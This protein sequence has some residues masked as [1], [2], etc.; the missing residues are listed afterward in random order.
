MSSVKRGHISIVVDLT[1]GYIHRTD[2]VI[3]VEDVDVTRVVEL[4]GETKENST[5]L[6]LSLINQS[7]N[8]GP[9]II[10]LVT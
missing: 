1:I 3:N 6:F 4:A 2:R 10:M 5:Y 8:V 7:V 9:D